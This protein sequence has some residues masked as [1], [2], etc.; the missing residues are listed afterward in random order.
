VRDQV[1]V[2]VVS[3]LYRGSMFNLFKRKPGRPR[4]DGEQGLQR[5]ADARMQMDAMGRLPE[6]VAAGGSRHDP[7]PEYIAE[8]ATPSED[9]WARVQAEYRAKNEGQPGT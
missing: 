3:A 4:I 7:A 1:L 6:D 8:A 9:V 5:I 2:G